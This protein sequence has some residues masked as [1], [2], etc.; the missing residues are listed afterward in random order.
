[1]MHCLSVAPGTVYGYLVR[2]LTLSS[3]SLTLTLCTNY[4]SCAPPE[5]GVCVFS[6]EAFRRAQ[7]DRSPSHIHPSGS[8]FA[9]RLYELQVRFA[10][11]TL[12]YERMPH[13]WLNF[14]GDPFLK[15]LQTPSHPT[16]SENERKR[17]TT[18]RALVLYGK[19]RCYCPPF[20]HA[21]KLETELQYVRLSCCASSLRP[22]HQ[23][24]LLP[25]WTGI[26]T[27]SCRYHT[28]NGQRSLY[29][30]PV[31]HFIQPASNPFWGGVGGGRGR[32]EE[33]AA[34]YGTAPVTLT[35]HVN[36]AVWPLPTPV[37]GPLLNY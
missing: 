27:V 31:I 19:R 26:Y 29:C 37:L 32:V 4:K 33:K 6:K 10:Q 5:T 8:I 16:E 15:S 12:N 1:M 35:K 30:R 21:H 24:C 20:T 14:D 25:P 2:A 36:E 13:G 7:T 22:L 28:L 17:I 3:K 18:Y 9:C 34:E 11:L 23:V